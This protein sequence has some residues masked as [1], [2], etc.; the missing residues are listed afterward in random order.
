M[1]MRGMV[2]QKEE[3]KFMTFD[4]STMMIVSGVVINLFF[5][6][7]FCFSTTMMRGF[8]FAALLFW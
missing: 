8:R 5:L 3:D 2:W 1:R 7:F 4:T 6:F